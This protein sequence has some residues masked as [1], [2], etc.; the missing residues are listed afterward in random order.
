MLKLY[1][2]KPD[3]RRVPCQGLELRR[4]CKNIVGIFVLKW[5][6]MPNTVP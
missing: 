5:V 4:V 2:K 6:I 3:C 1:R